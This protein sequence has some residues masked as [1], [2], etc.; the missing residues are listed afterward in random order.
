MNKLVLIGASLLLGLAF[1]TCHSDDPNYGD[2][3]PPTVEVAPNTLSG[4]VTTIK[5]QPINGATV[6]VG[7]KMATTNSDGVY[8]ISGIVAG[9]YTV[10]ASAGGM[11]SKE[12]SLVIGDSKNTQNF[13]WSTA[14]PKVI[15]ENVNVTVEDGG[16]GV[17]ESEAIEG[18]D[19]GKVKISVDV[20]ANTV[21]ENTTISI[22]PI[23]TEESVMVTRVG[24]RA[25]S[26]RMLI[27]A[28]VKCNNPNLALLNTIDVAFAVDATVAEGVETRQYV[29]GQWTPVDHHANNNGVIVS[30]KNFG[31]IGLFFS[32]DITETIG[33]ETLTFTPNGWN[34]LYGANEVVATVAN[35]TYKAGSEYNASGAYTLEALLIERLASIVGP[36]YKNI[37]GEYPVNVNVPVGTAI[38]FSGKQTTKNVTVSSGDQSASG[39]QFGTVSVIVASHNRRHNGSGNQ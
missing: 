33:S 3:Q 4:V 17:A 19:K 29:N 36:A 8:Q 24:S 1:M 2:V 13:T 6:T 9:T 11:I 14:L 12:A 5:G 39:T 30:T 21:P 35:Y 37:Q 10:K 38:T 18:N 20:A 25:L 22:S 31:P 7:N 32:V 34:N 26:D 27:G 16:N 23:Y 28:D 15:V